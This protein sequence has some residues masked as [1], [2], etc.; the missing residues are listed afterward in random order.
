MCDFK[1]Q[2]KQIQLL[3]NISMKKSIIQRRFKLNLHISNQ[4]KLILL[5]DANKI[6][7]NTFLCWD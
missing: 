6:N 7:L 3:I 4:A 5:V 2:E 1:V